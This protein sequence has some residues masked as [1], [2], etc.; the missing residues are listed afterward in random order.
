[1]V[2]GPLA[3]LSLEP[4]RGDVVEV[5]GSVDV[6]GDDDPPE[7]TTP[8]TPPTTASATSAAMMRV[9]SDRFGTG[10]PASGSVWPALGGGKGTP[11]G[12]LGGISRH[13]RAR[14]SAGVDESEAGGS[15]GFCEFTKRQG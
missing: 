15:N 7:I 14:G 13:V 9:R 8:V 2:D 5:L 1:V 11:S 10:A 3:W 12:G 4:S 6:L